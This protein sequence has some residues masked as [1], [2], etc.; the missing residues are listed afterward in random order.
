[1][2]ESH[3]MQQPAVDPQRP[4]E[5][6]KPE[7]TA[8]KIAKYMEDLRGYLR[9]WE[10]RPDSFLQVEDYYDG[11]LE[12]LHA[13][14]NNKLRTAWFNVLSLMQLIVQKAKLTL[15][16]L[17]LDAL[18]LDLQQIKKQEESAVDEFIK[19]RGIN[20]PEDNLAAS[21]VIKKIKN[22]VAPKLLDQRIKLI[23]RVEESIELLLAKLEELLWQVTN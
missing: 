3:L 23:H 12:K 18:N 9:D 11:Q 17:E 19:E 10:I 16:E 7:I 14:R 4:E 6:K 5:K 20:L 1:M 8:E 15:P 13:G 21:D 2:A 22:Q